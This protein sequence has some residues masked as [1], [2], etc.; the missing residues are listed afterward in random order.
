MTPAE[1]KEAMDDMD[2]DH[3][4]TVDYKEFEDYWL[5][6][7]SGDMVTGTKLAAT[8]AKW[9]DAEHIG[10]IAYHPDRYID[11]DDEF[12]ARV[13]TVFDDIDNNHD[14]HIS[15]IEFIKCAYVLWLS[16]SGFKST[17]CALVA[18]GGRG[19][20]KNFITARLRSQTKF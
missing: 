11:P 14:E 18:A 19:K 7:F 1:L 4:G 20:T 6:T 15:Y 3:G 10:G 9:A 17:P 2:T 8:I 12:R 13:W 16:N 5:K